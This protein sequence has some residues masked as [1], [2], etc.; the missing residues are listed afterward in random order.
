[1][2]SNVFQIKPPM[3]PT[4]KGQPQEDVWQKEGKNI[5]QKP[6]VFSSHT[7]LIQHILVVTET[8]NV[9]LS[10]ER[11][12]TTPGCILPFTQCMLG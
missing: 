6:T 4:L 7:V 11:L 9:A 5:R 8:I 1:M 3:N 10:A 2:I 12:V